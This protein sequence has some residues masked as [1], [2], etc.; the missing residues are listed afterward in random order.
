[1]KKP[2]HVYDVSNMHILLAL[3][4][5]HCYQEILKLAPDDSLIVNIGA[6]VGTSAITALTEKKN[7]LI[8]SIDILPC[9]DERQYAIDIGLEHER[10]IRILGR[11]QDVGKYWNIPIDVLFVDGEHDYDSVYWDTF[12]W[13]PHVKQG[14]LLVFH[15][16]AHTR[17]PDVTKVVDAL[18]RNN[19]KYEVVGAER[20]LI[21]FRVK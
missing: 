12:L 7:S 20:F 8:F 15:D 18:I 6:S 5:V 11:S 9:L 14:G 19:S 10:I 1:M 16:Y 13:S 4:E 21:G 2:A 17:A 3:S